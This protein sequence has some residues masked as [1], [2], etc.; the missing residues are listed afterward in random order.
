MKNIIFLAFFSLIFSCCY[1]NSMDDESKIKCDNF[2]YKDGIV[3]YSDKKLNE[4]VLVIKYKRNEDFKTALD[5]FKFDYYKS[6]FNNRVGYGVNNINKVL[7]TG[8]DYKII[9][10]NE[11]E[12]KITNIKSKNYTPG[13]DFMSGKNNMCVIE[14]YILNDSLIKDNKNFILI[15]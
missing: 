11:K 3:I 9:I 10:N 6:T 5:T 2:D 13:G 8:F 1:T 14:S 12:Y 15:Y 7:N 4:Y